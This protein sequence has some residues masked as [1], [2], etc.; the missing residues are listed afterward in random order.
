MHA[1][2]GI[3]RHIWGKKKKV[4]SIPSKEL[5]QQNN[6]HILIISYAIANPIM[7]FQSFR[8]QKIQLMAKT[9]I[10]DGFK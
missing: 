10:G 3:N 4:E 7:I 9:T 6:L 2:L 1:N 5:I 8:I